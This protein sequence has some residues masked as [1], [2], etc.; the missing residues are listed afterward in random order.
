MQ[1][2]EENDEEFWNKLQK[3]I[4]VLARENRG[5]RGGDENYYWIFEELECARA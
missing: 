1:K 5:G 2:G 3:E 4:E